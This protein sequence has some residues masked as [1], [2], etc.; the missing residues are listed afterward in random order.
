MVRLGFATDLLLAPKVVPIRDMINAL[1][2]RRDVGLLVGKVGWR[3]RGC[4]LVG[5]QGW[6]WAT[7]SPPSATSLWNTSMA[8]RPGSA[9]F[10]SVWLVYID[11]RMLIDITVKAAKLKIWLSLPVDRK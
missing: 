11:C 7:D 6:V 10:M 4:W 3:V 5:W 2:R 9:W 1:A 8:V